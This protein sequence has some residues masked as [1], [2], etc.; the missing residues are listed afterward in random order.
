VGISRWLAGTPWN[1]GL[2]KAVSI[3]KML[4]IQSS[5]R[6]FRMDRR[7]FVSLTALATVSLATPEVFLGAPMSKG[8]FGSFD[9]VFFT[10]THSYP[11]LNADGG[12]AMCYKK[13]RSHHADFAIQGGDHTLDVLAVDRQRANMLYDLYTKTEQA[14]GLK[15]YHAVGNHDLFG[16]DPKSGIAPS[17]PGYGKRMFEERFGSTYYSYDHKGYH[18]IVLNSIQPMESRSWEARIDEQQL[19]WLKRDLENNGPDTPVVVA[20][21]V[22][23]VTGAASYGPFIKTPNQLVIVNAHEVLRLF[24][25]HRILAVLQGHIHVNE[26][27][28][29]RG[30]PYIC[31]GAVCGN[32]WHGTRWGTPE[33]YTVVSLRD[34]KISWRYETYG[35]KSVDP[36]NT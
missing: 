21:H 25:G 11:E 1:Y 9:F 28:N 32:W 3:S 4:V 7:Q 15:V 14:I 19:V 5:K 29:F 23:L 34:G 35:F 17:E 18:F 10:D 26:V 36:M 8:T 33:G 2:A 31:S 30:I 22:P 24:A 16:I 6:R 20:V 27:V 12:C 13:I